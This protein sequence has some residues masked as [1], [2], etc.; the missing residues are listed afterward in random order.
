MKLK[1]LLYITAVFL[2]LLPS[3]FM[4]TSAYGQK[5]KAVSVKKQNK[6]NRDVKGTE[7]GK[8]A[9]M[10]EVE[11]ELTKKH[12]RIQDKAT[13]KRMKQTKKKSKR[14]KSNKKEPFFKRWFRKK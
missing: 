14:L 4:P 10:K 3:S 2:V 5:S 12:M 1:L 13:R 9:Q 11:D 8:R 7:E 6:K